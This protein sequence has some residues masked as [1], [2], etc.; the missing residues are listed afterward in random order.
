MVPTAIFTSPPIGTVGLSEHEAAEEYGDDVEIFETNFGGLKYSFTDKAKTPRTFMKLI[1]QR[2]TDRVLGVH[3]AGDDA[4][5][6]IQGFAV[7]LTAGA[8]KS[9]F[10]ATLAI[11]PSSAEEL[12]LLKN[13]RDANV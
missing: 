7:A 5:E 12:V 3:I 4:A 8:T 11:H 1:R 10:D 9:Q 6:M 13:G 2:S